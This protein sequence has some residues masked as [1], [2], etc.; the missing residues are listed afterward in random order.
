M[1]ITSDQ[2]DGTVTVACDEVPCDVVPEQQI[3]LAS[4][5][6]ST[7]DIALSATTAGQTQ[8]LD[9]R[10]GQVVSDVSQVAYA[11]DGRISVSTTWPQTTHVVRTEEQLETEIGRSMSD[12][13]HGGATYTY[14]GAI[15][16]AYL[17]PFDARQGW[18]PAGQAWLVVPIVDDPAG[19]NG[20]WRADIDPA[21]T[22]TLTVDDQVLTNTTDGEN[23][24]AVFLVD[25]DITDATFTY[26]PTG[27]LSIPHHDV[28]YPL[29][30]DALTATI[31]TQL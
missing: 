6:T 10:T 29:V 15:R 31:S 18:A 12:L 13:T 11:R 4:T 17:S 3:L 19:S 21:A 20:L 5:S 9:L 22:W 28:A 24:V 27:T 2:E 23:S 25:D 7:A 1:P 14:G 16:E 30:A 8:T 26:Q